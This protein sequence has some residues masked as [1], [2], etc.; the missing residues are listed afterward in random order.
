MKII[1][2]AIVVIACLAIFCITFYAYYGGFDKLNVRIAEQ[3][4]ETVVYEEFIGDYSKS[5]AAMDTVYYS[6]KNI[7]KIETFKGFGIY[8]DNPKTIERSK[9]R[10]EVGCIIENADIEKET[11][12]YDRFFF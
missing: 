5:G 9:L 6:L 2:I 1:K 12:H 10:S 7:D 3:G 8:Y 4:G 11:I